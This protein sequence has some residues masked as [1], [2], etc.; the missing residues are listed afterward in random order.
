MVP[1][2]RYSHDKIGSDGSSVRLTSCVAVFR[3]VFGV[4]WPTCRRVWIKHTSRRCWE[5]IRRNENMR[6][7]CSSASWYPF[8]HFMLRSSQ[9]FLRSSS[10]RPHRL[11]L[12]EICG[13]W[14]QKRR[15]CPLVLVL[16]PS[17]IGKA[18]KSYNSRISPSKNT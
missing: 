4:P 9:I 6:N 8:A 16:L 11:H 15:C 12:T 17:S 13:L 2:T 7:D 14:M 18:N 1:Q 10:M 5:S 3:P